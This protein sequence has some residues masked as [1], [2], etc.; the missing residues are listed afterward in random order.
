ME[1]QKNESMASWRC[2]RYQKRIL[3]REG[4]MKMKRRR[5]EAK[6]RRSEEERGAEE[7]KERQQQLLGGSGPDPLQC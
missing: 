1:I 7:E 3:E 4:N 6:K 5:E 2:R